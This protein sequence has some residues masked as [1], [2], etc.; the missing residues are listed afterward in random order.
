MEEEK[1]LQLLWNR[2]EPA[3]E[4]LRTA[5]GPTLYK[6]ALNILADPQDA[7]EAVSDTYLALWNAI[8][9]EHPD[10]LSAYAYRTCRNI[11]LKKLR[12]RSAQKRQSDYDLS[13][14]ELADFLPGD[15]LEQTLNARD[16]GK[17]IDRFLDTLPKINRVL[18]IRRY[19][20]GEDMKALAKAVGMTPNAA[21]VR[22][23]RIRRQLKQYLIKEGYLYE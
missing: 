2:S 9:P 5:Y 11:A 18:F 14:D 22:I 3:I 12:H 1:L 20:F 21:T 15:D 17:A 16:L 4:H 19:W 6:I 7:E 10:P 8:P 23:S 13:L